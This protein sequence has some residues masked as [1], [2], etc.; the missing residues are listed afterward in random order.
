M[1][2]ESLINPIKAEK[3]PWELLFIGMI[4]SSVA[5]ILSLFIFP[6]YASLVMI[7]LTVLAAG[8]L[9]F[10]AIKLEE[11]KDIEL[12]HERFLVKEHARALSF[13]MFLFLGFIISFSLWNIFLPEELSSELF[14]IQSNEIHKINNNAITGDAVSNMKVFGNIFFNN[15]YVMLFSLLFAFFY[16][17]GAIFILTWNATIIGAAVGEFVSGFIGSSYLVSIP[18]A[19]SRY[20]LHG[21]P[22]MFAYFLAGLAGSIISVA[23]IRHD[24]GTGKFKHILIDSLDMIFLAVIIIFFAALLEVF[25]TPVI[26]Y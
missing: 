13:F 6:E 7:F 18:V 8:P 15:I 26:F 19:L 10:G 4:Y 5:V 23:V 3:H 14:K 17:I 2:F 25:V 1:V 24:F 12:K 16:G 22:E 11:K 9:M 20:L 21:I